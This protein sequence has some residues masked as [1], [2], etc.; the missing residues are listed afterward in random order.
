MGAQD[1]LEQ[2][3]DFVDEYGTVSLQMLWDPGFDSWSQLGIRG[4]PAFAIFDRS[5]TF[6]EGWYGGVSPEE[7]LDIVASL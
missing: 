1:S 3:E 5:G 2:A 7:V 4:Q 6:Q